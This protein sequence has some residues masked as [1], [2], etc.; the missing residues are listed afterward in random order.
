MKLAYDPRALAEMRREARWYEARAPGLGRAMLDLV[1]AALLAIAEA[2]M[3]F[4][5]VPR[6]PRYRRAILRRYPFSIVF[7]V[8]DGF[9]YVVAFA[10]AKR[11][12][13]YWRR[14]LG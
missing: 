1:D 6:A 7:T 12:P 13:L 10:H 8:E 2:P 11:R 14:R 9:V 3:S 4:P 5:R